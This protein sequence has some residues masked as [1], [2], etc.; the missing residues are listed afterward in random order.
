MKSKK[1]MIFLKV[2]CLFDFYFFEKQQNYNFFK[3]MVID[4]IYYFS[5][6]HK[7]TSR[8][9]EVVGVFSTLYHGE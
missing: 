3:G 5:K 9:V 7:L 4:L 1:I 2:L 8:R 6:K